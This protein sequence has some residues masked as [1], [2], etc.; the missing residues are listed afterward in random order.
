[1]NQSSYIKILDAIGKGKTLGI[2]ILE[3]RQDETHQ[4]THFWHILVNN[5]EVVNSAAM[6][7]HEFLHF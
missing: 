2:L 6:K 1:M 7:L 5:F 3:G 4:L